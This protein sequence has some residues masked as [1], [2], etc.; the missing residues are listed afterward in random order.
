MRNRNKLVPAIIAIVVGGHTAVSA[1]ETGPAAQKL[2]SSPATIAAEK[3]VIVQGIAVTPAGN[4]GSADGRHTLRLKGLVGAGYDSNIYATE[5]D[6]IDDYYGRV[7]AGFES[8]HRYNDRFSLGTDVLLD[9]KAYQDNS[10]RNLLGGQARVKGVYKGEAVSGNLAVDYL[11]MD[12]PLIQTGE[13]IKRSS[14]GANTVWMREMATGG[15]VVNAD[16]HR[17]EYLE[18]QGGFVAED[19]NYNSYIAGIRYIHQQNDRSALW[20]RVGFGADLYDNDNRFQD[21]TSVSAAVGADFALGDRSTAF[22]EAGVDSRTYSDEFAPSYDDDSV[23][24]P[25]LSIGLVY[26]MSTQGDVLKL[27][28]YTDAR[29]SFSANAM[30]VVG[31]ELDVRHPMSEQLTAVINLSQL[32]LNDYGAAPGEDENHRSTFI[33]SLAVEYA[34]SDGVVLRGTGRWTISEASNETEQDYD[35]TEVFVETAFAF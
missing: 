22:F 35:R 14:Y 26:P 23:L 19:N 4:L 9:G 24:A 12:D 11:L 5:E 3:Q 33:P 20:G 1:A 29:N 32:W 21:V 31:G 27:R 30:Q 8:V 2:A 17:M 6:V 7:M 10:D 18:D 28:A 34:L 15:I 16:A 13:K 25:L